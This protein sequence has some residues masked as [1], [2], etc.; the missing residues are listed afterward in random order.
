[1]ST[2]RSAAMQGVLDRLKLLNKSQGWLAAQLA[3]HVTRQSVSGWHDIP[4]HYI[5][6]VARLLDVEPATVRPDLAA[7]F[8]PTR[9]DKRGLCMAVHQ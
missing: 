8:E 9:K 6:Q 4:D 7:H 3:P 5:S 2:K 1:M